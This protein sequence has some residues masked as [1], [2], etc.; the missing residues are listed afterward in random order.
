MII[1]DLEYRDNLLTQS[2]RIVGGR[3]VFAFASGSASGNRYSRVFT[4]T[5][6][7]Y[8]SGTIKLW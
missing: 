3:R 4:K 6:A 5:V 7:F 1:K 2:L 8:K